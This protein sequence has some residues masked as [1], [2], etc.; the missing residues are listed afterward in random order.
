M[1]LNTARCHDSW[2]IFIVNNG[3]VLYNRSF[4]LQQLY[5]PVNVS[6]SPRK[7]VDVD[8]Q[9]MIY[10]PD[11][12]EFALVAQYIDGKKC[13]SDKSQYEQGS[14]SGVPG[15]IIPPIRTIPGV[16]GA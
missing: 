3:D 11:N 6:K 14:S 9:L 4:L 2:S 10:D 16:K 5:I 7:S 13:Q 8:N 1:S 15:H 12:W